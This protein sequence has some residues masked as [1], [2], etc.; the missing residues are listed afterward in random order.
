MKTRIHVHRPTLARNLK[1]GTDDPAVS[2]MTY[3]GTTHHHEVEILGP[4]KMIQSET[5]LSC[6]ARV[7]VETQAEVRIVR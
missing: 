5:P 3:R 7:W 4:S 6:G 1:L 2:V